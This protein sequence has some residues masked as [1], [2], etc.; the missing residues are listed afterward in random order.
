ML[1]TVCSFY[2]LFA[3]GLSFMRIPFVIVRIQFF[4]AQNKKIVE[5]IKL[6]LDF[7][8]AIPNVDTNST[9][10]FVAVAYNSFILCVRVYGFSLAKPEFIEHNSSTC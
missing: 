8:R 9:S 10:L 2:A 7:N 3:I 1:A 4:S 5:C 6:K